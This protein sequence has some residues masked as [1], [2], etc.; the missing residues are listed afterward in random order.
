MKNLWNLEH[1]SKFSPVYRVQENMK[2][3][4]THFYFLMSDRISI[5]PLILYNVTLIVL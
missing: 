4:F 2:N 1:S 3:E 5:F